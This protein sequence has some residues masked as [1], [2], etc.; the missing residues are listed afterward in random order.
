MDT[1]LLRIM[2]L[3][4]VRRAS[5][6]MAERQH[7]SGKQL[8]VIVY[9]VPCKGSDRSSCCRL[10]VIFKSPSYLI[11]DAVPSVRPPR[12]LDIDL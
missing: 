3:M 4:F 12:I 2:T 7:I 9:Y 1:P 6:K 5:V 8:A 11:R 10:S